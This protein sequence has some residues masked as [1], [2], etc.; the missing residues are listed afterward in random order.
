M[1]KTRSIRDFAEIADFIAAETMAP[2]DSF[3][4]AFEGGLEMSRLGFGEEG[5]TVDM[6]DPMQAQL[7]TEMLVSTLFDVLRDTR[8][9][10]IAPRLAW[11]IVHS[12]HKVAD[13]LDGEADRAASQIRD[14]VRSADGSEIMTAELEE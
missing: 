10:S 5:L 11:G 1:T 8:L 7:A 2:A 14:L 12:F 3:V 4:V 6:P 9:E 13:Q